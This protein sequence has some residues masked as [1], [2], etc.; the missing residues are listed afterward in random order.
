[1]RRAFAL[2]GVIALMSIPT[3]VIVAM[4]G[5]IGISFVVS[6]FA[7]F[8]V[9]IAASIGET[10]VL[11]GAGRAADLRDRGGPFMAAVGVLALVGLVALHQVPGQA[12]RR[13]RRAC[14][15]VAAAAV[16]LAGI[17]DL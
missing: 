14:R 7:V 10:A 9:G 15:R 2:V 16:R 11:D 4:L 8:V 17:C 13:M 3:I 1:M 12:T 5:S 6:G